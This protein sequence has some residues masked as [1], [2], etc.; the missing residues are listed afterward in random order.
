MTINGIRSIL[1]R[2]ARLLGDAQAIGKASRRGSAD[3]IV[4]RIGRRLAGRLTGRIL[5]RIFR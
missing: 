4:K 2:L 1:Y 3:P 5:G